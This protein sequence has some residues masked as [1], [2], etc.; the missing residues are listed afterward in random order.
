MLCKIA[1]SAHTHAACADELALCVYTVRASSHDV[2]I[3]QMTQMQI[4]FD[5]QV[6]EKDEELQ[7]KQ[8][9]LDQCQAE[10]SDCRKTVGIKFV[11]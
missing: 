2:S 6:R 1:D 11:M 3:V 8:R 5:Q 7:S 10:L 9:E 4:K